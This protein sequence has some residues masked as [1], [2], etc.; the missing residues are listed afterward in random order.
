MIN[1]HQA[2]LALGS[3]VFI[4]LATDLPQKKVDSI[5]AV[6]WLEI[7]KFEQQ[8]SR[9][10]PTSELSM[11]NR[12]AGLPYPVSESFRDLLITAKKM[13]IKTKGL[14]NPFIL[15]MLQK[16][17]YK[18][19]FVDK[20]HNDAIDDYS[21]R[22]VASIEKLKIDDDSVTIP[23]NTAMD[24]G[25]IG[26]GYLADQL[27]KNPEL[28]MLNG[29]WISLGGDVIGSGLDADGTKWEV[30]I[31][32]A[33]KP[34]KLI[35]F[36]YTSEEKNFSVATSGTITRKSKNDTKP[37]HHIID[38]RTLKPAITDVLLASVA[39][40]TSTEADIFASCAVI[41]GSKDAPD[42][43][44]SVGISSYLLQLESDSTSPLLISTGNFE[45]MNKTPA[46]PSKKVI[47][48]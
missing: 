41:L 21:H 4:V 34:D 12:N 28:D 26:K 33:I 13:A 44:Q 6:L 7:F 16:A 24:F 48:L 36:H 43:L 19:S 47:K 17:G 8:F 2:K 23:A 14:Y 38:P 10:L 18:K 1:H 46:K 5:F 35:N 25:G 42:F 40:K 27:A 15:P 29:Y 37:W 9:F 22:A 45:K 39:A 30:S 11:F 3:D 31:Q 20:Y 32:D